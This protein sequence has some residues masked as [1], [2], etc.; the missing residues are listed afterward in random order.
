MMLRCKRSSDLRSFSGEAVVRTLT[1]I[2]A[3][4]VLSLA[5]DARAD[6]YGCLNGDKMSYVNT[7]KELAKRKAVEEAETEGGGQVPVLRGAATACEEA[8]PRAPKHLRGRRA[9][10]QQADELAMHARCSVAAARRGFRADHARSGAAGQQNR[11]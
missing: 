4:S 6:I 10:T 7:A 11:A 5:P 8:S 9:R 3:L 1:F 2:L